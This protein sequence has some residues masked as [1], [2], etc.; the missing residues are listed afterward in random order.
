M[1]A[2]LFCFS[3][4]LIL[5]PF[6]YLSVIWVWCTHNQSM[7]EASHEYLVVYIRMKCD[8]G[9]LCQWKWQNLVPKSNIKKQHLYITCIVCIHTTMNTIWRHMN[10]SGWF[11]MK[12]WMHG[13]GK[14][15][16]SKC[17]MDADW[18]WYIY[19]LLP[20]SGYIYL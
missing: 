7:L 11:L 4:L 12:C 19:H 10:S 15:H 17:W 6:A 16:I 13:N 1:W 9:C 14:Y 2:I 20:P 18:L 3:L 5:Q 8:W